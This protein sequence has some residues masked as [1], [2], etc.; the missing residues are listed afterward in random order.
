MKGILLLPGNR[1]LY[2][3]PCLAHCLQASGSQLGGSA[4]PSAFRFQD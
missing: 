4:W 1:L 2:G 3:Q